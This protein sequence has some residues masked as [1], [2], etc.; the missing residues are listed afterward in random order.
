MEKLN[1][2]FS[3]KKRKKSTLFSH[4]TDN[5]ALKP[6]STSKYV[7]VIKIRVN[8]VFGLYPLHY[9]LIWSIIFQCYVNLVLNII[10]WIEIADVAKDQNK[11]LVSV[12]VT[13]N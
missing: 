12:N 8:Y 1:Y 6:Y 4:C 2:Y 7:L 11:K 13:I 10:F 5:Y 9:I 3:K